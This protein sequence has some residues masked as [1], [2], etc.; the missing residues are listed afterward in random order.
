MASAEASQEKPSAKSLACLPISSR[1]S[2][3]SI[4]ERSAWAN[5]GRSPW[6]TSIPVRLSTTDSL[7]PGE[8]LATVAVP[9]AP[10]SMQEIPHPSLG[11]VIAC[12]HDVRSRSSDSNSVSVT[13]G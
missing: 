13:A 6:G 11:D 9:H 4:N 2:R 1:R 5:A 12:S 10:A 3:S 7:R 8:S